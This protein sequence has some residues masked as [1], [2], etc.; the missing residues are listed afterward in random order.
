MIEL[1]VLLFVAGA[2]YLITR[3]PRFPAPRARRPE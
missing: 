3:R 2:I 1:L